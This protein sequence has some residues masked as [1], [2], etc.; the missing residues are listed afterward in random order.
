MCSCVN[1]E[2][3]VAL[4]LATTREPAGTPAGGAR[5]VT[6]ADS[7][8]EVDVADSSDVVVGAS[9]DALALPVLAR[10]PNRA[11]MAEITSVAAADLDASL[12]V[13]MV[14]EKV[15]CADE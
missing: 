4:E 12:S 9:S 10:P 11:F 8:S 15:W 13:L 1:I 3:V 7:S 5:A 6:E 2:F 14:K